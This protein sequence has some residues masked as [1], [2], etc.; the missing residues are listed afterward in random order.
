[1]KYRIPK[2]WKPISG[3]EQYALCPDNFVVNLKTGKRLSRYWYNL[4]YYSHVV[5]DNGDYRRVDHNDLDVET[6]G[7]P[8][9]EMVV[10]E[11]YPDYKVT[12]YGAVW[13]YRNTCKRYRNNPFLVGSKDI[14]DKEYVR[15]KTEDGRAHWV[16]M[17]KIMDA[18]YP[19]Y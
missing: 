8:E 4:R 6:F 19:D 10:I 16:R 14:G 17:E 12:P 3:A 5:D 7:L 2:G 11:D 18:A 13:K 15:L 9:E 1:M